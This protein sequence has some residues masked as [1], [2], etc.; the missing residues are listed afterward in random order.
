M[1]ELTLLKQARKV[2]FTLKECRKL[3]EL[4]RNARRQSADIKA[5]TLNKISEIEK[6]ITEL[7]FDPR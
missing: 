1:E 7:I 6:T 3:L 4:F 5:A 2:G